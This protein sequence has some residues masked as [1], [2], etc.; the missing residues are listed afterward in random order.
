MAKKNGH[1]PSPTNGSTS[2]SPKKSR[3]KKI[4]PA[5]EAI[6]LRA[7]EIYLER[8]GAPGNPLEDWVR[9]E[10]ELLHAGGKKSAKFTAKSA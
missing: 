10:N 2:S 3:S 6:Q 8:N 7:Y 9:A 1:V 5:T 4:A